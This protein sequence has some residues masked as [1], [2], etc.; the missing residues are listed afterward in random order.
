MKMDMKFAGQIGI[1]ISRHLENDDI[2]S[3]YG[4]LEPILS[5]RTRFPHLQ[6][7]GETTAR[8]T[9]DGVYAF[10]DHIGRKGTEGGWVVIGGALLEQMGSNLSL[11]HQHCRRHIISADIW[12]G[13]DILGERVP[14]PGLL[15]DFQA[16]L[17][18]L[19]FWRAD[20]NPWVR[21]SVGAA[22]HH[23]TKRNGYGPS[24]QR[25]AELLLDLL[26]PMFGEWDLNAA[27]GVGWA[28]KTIGKYHPDLLMAWLPSRLVRAH[29]AVVRSK[30]LTYLPVGFI[31]QAD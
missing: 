29:R 22:V 14:G 19:K 20:P 9:G 21:R 1:E 15:A 5:T 30:A 3:A 24:C 18:I 11:A 23:W 10:L 4:V 16:V 27:K 7:I 8:H 25:E 26:D 6:R 31:D 28:L 17:P 12:Y 13:A 2:P